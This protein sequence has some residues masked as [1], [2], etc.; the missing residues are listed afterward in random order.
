MCVDI[1]TIWFTQIV[2][3]CTFIY[4]RS[5]LNAGIYKAMWHIHTYIHIWHMWVL[6]T[7]N[8]TSNQILY[9]LFN[10]RT[11]DLTT[12]EGT[13]EFLSKYDELGWS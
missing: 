8:I 1:K 7:N 5:T 2:D 11:Q 3:Y 9:Y 10:L 4:R 13:M 12:F 6:P